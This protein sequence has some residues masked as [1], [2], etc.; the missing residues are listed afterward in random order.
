MVKFAFTGQHLDRA[1]PRRGDAEFIKAA[2][3]DSST[4]FVIFFKGNAL[5]TRDKAVAA[6]WLTLEQLTRL[7][8]PDSPPIFLGVDGN[9]A[10]FVVDLNETMARHFEDDQFLELWRNAHRFSPREGGIL[11][12]AKAMLE[13]HRRHRFCGRTGAP[14]AVTK[15]GHQLVGGEGHHQFPRVDPAI[16]VLVHAGDR[17]L[18]GRQ[19]SWPE[20]HYSTI[21]GFVEPGE[22]LEDAV[23]REVAEETNIVVEAVEYRGS[24]P[25]PFP[26]SL[27]VGFHASAVSQDIVCNDGELADA[28]WFSR[29]ELRTGDVRLPPPISISFHLIE[30]WFD[31]GGSG[32]PLHDVIAA[33]GRWR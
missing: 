27:M 15:G 1:A 28:R 29:E 31:A 9:S 25:W 10:V 20:G 5:V 4:R 7:G 16:I 21:A 23:I 30:T 12:Y 13:W 2:L 19:A 14:N 3:R 8:E 11:A 18:L 33:R 22:N 24:Q 17:C 26:S 6:R 32:G